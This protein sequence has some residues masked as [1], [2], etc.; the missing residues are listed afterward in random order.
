MTVSEKLAWLNQ[1]VGVVEASSKEG[2]PGLER[3]SS[4]NGVNTLA[5]MMKRYVKMP[6]KKA[7]PLLFIGSL[8]L[9]ATCGCTQQPRG[10]QS[11]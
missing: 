2:L 9:I 4:M 5:T 11:P 6:L 3:I 8:V 1:T 7:L 10:G